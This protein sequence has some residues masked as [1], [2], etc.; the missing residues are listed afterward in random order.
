MVHKHHPLIITGYS[1]GLPFEDERFAF[2]DKSA[3]K[4]INEF[5]ADPDIVSVHVEPLNIHSLAS[6][7][8]IVSLRD[9]YKALKHDIT[10]RKEIVF[11]RH[12]G[13]PF[14]PEKYVKIIKGK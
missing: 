6:S 10:R 14:K 11:V 5:R 7:V 8:S 12:E 1:K 13:N 4:L 2:S 3:V 9:V